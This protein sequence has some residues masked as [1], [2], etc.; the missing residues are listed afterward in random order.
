[1]KTFDVENF[2][3]KK[4]I[5]SEKNDF[6]ILD[7]ICKKIDV[8]N[9]VF[10]FYTSDLAKKISPEEISQKAYKELYKHFINDD[11]V[12]FKFINTAYKLND[13]LYQSKLLTDGEYNT[14]K[15]ELDGK[16]K[17]LQIGLS[18]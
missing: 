7:R 17:A 2:I 10:K 18:N 14:N 3:F 8:V 13:K 15:L 12:D 4:D 5:F 16:V 6:F 1:M 9:K 11:V